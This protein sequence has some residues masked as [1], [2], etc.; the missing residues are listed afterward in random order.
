ME[1]T[2]RQGGHGNRIGGYKYNFICVPKT[3]PLALDKTSLRQI[4]QKDFGIFFFKNIIAMSFDNKNGNSNVT[5]EPLSRPTTITLAIIASIFS[6]V[7]IIGNAC[8][9]LVLLRSPTFRAKGHFY[10]FHLKI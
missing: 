10:K 3:Y 2:G 7:G 9:I 8:T 5:T 4:Y 1:Q 6:F